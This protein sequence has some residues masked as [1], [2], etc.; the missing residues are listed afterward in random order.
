LGKFAKVVKYIFIIALVAFLAALLLRICQSDYKALEDIKITDNFVSA[1]KVDSDIRT[2]AVNDGFSENGAVF[3]YS[4][5]YMEDGG[6]LQLTVRYNVRHIDEVKNE[7]PDFKEEYI[8][9]TLTDENG[10]T[11]VP[12]V[13]DEERKYNYQYYKLEFTDIDSFD[14]DLKINMILD[15]IDGNVSKKNVLVIHRGDDTSIAYEISRSEEK[16][17]LE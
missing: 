11:Y 8:R 4:L 3:G 7:Y 2:H 9:Y 16:L 5:V 12:N 10:K 13:I 14:K 17:L 6:Y 1:Y 15:N